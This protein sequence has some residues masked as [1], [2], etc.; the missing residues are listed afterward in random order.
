M[1]KVEWIDIELTSVCGIHCQGCFRELS[2]YAYLINNKKVLD[3]ET[4][5]KR[6]KKEDFPDIKI[7]N[8][9]GSV[10]EPCAHPKFF[11]VVK[12]FATW[13][14]HIN[15]AT[16]GSLRT[17][18][19]WTE[20]A[21]Y[22]PESHMV[23]WGI[24]GTDKTSELYRV[25][26]DFNKVE[27]NYKAF[28]EAG[29]RATWQFI[30]FEHNQHQEQEVKIK[31]LDEGFKN[32]K[33]I[34]SHRKNDG[35][36]GN[37]K[38]KKIIKEE[39]KEIQCKYKAQNRIFVNHMGNVI[40]CCHLNSEMLEYAV[41]REENTKFTKILNDNQGELAVNLKYNEIQEVMEGDVWQGIVDA[42]TDEPISKCYTTC[43]KMVH[44]TFIQ[45]KL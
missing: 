4:I 22:L 30:V 7:I 1:W 9:C 45:E 5:K 35:T 26:S 37:V 11:E 34:Y 21:S 18:K 39:T 20:L 25:G 27:R 40:P 12:Y 24:D 31:A 29:G 44:D 42:W 41:G 16:S 38:H 33:Y 15:I 43:K 3:L 14:A 2:D 28:I 17:T 19:W 10:D 8:F 36:Q 32:V 23:T 13:G 6:F